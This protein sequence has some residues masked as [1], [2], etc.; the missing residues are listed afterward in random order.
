MKLF[1]K[2]K[3]FYKMLL[4][5]AIPI[6]L[7]NLVTVMVS[8]MDTLMIGQLGEIQL[9]ATSIANQLWFMLMICCFGI[10]GGANVLLA[11]Y[12]GKGDL[13]V[14]R[15]IQAITFKVTFAISL[16][17]V[18]V[19]QVFP[20]QFMGIFTPDPETIA[21]GAS[22]LRIVGWSYPL[23]ALANAAIMMLRSVGTVNISVIVYLVS[24]IV[25]TC[26]NYVLIFGHFG[27]PRM[28]IRGAAVGTA[29]S[30]CFEF[31]ITMVFL[32]SKEKKIRFS[33]KDL[34]PNNRD[35]YRKYIA[36]SVPVIGNEAMWGIGASMVAVVIG[37][38]G[39][40]FVAANSIYTVL[41]QLVTVLI[42]GVGNAALTI[43]GNTIGTGNYELAKQRALTLYILGAGIGILA[44][45]LTLGLGPVLIRFYQNLT[46]ETVEIL[47]KIILVGAVIVFFQA[48]AVVGM[49]GVLR[50]GGD[51]RFVFICEA[52]F[53]WGVAVP[54]GFLTGLVLGW[55]APVVFFILKSDEVLK[56]MVST[57]RILRFR[58]LRDITVS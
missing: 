39:T 31:G 3:E 58:W 13:P 25:N 2:D 41:N 38:M 12:W 30:R 14:M 4:M 16:L 42:F 19:S 48:L 56:T 22:Y 23:Y 27:A 9:S 43:V 57:V 55:P 11:Q 10:A 18:L 29:L 51:S 46:P 1:V 36:Q 20:K 49:V 45:G 44:G 6:A 33:L 53:L 52:S 15:R 8:M 26:V 35:L 32:L 40:N 47:E 17:F 21:L 37:R 50:A 34:L 5:I 28:E 54:L 7:Q 24:L